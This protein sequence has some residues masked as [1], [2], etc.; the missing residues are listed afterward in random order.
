M[1]FQQ[2]LINQTKP[3]SKKP[4]YKPNLACL[5][6]IGP[7]KLFLKVLTLLDVRDCSKLSLY[8]ISRKTDD[9]NARKL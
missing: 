1:Q 6:Q 5:A 9:P 2:K 3:N 4:N 7:P 8:A